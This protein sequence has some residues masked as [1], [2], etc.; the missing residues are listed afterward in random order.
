MWPQQLLPRA[1]V[2]R[3]ACAAR[4][5]S[6]ALT[7]RQMSEIDLKAAA[8]RANIA[9]A[10]LRASAARVSRRA[11]KSRVRHVQLGAFLAARVSRRFRGIRDAEVARLRLVSRRR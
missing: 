3:A 4:C 1:A 9:A 8:S 11:N 6:L 5:L 7:R 2:R 10:H